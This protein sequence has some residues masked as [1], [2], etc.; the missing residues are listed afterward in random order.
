MKAK[1]YGIFVPL[2]TAPSHQ[3]ALAAAPGKAISSQPLARVAPWVDAPTMITTR[4][5]PIRVTN[6]GSVLG[7]LASC[8]LLVLVSLRIFV[9]FF[10]CSRASLSWIR[11]LSSKKK[12]LQ[13]RL[14]GDAK[15]GLLASVSDQSQRK[16]TNIQFSQKGQYRE[17]FLERPDWTLGTCPTGLGGCAISSRI[18]YWCRDALH[19]GQ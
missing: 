8:S 14:Q 15:K 7:R 5:E 2:P 3:K 13:G 4:S 18:L 19:N 12:D 6:G 16:S 17:C 10:I 11:F 1:Q 9:S